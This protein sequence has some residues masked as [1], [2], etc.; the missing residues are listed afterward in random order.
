MKNRVE[1]INMRE[2]VVGSIFFVGAFGM[3]ILSLEL[4]F[5]M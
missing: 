5:K 3:L 4:V 2:K 1:S